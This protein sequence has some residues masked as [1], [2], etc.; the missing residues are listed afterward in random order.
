[1]RKMDSVKNMVRIPGSAPPPRNDRGEIIPVDPPVKQAD[2]TDS[3][4]GFFM[5]AAA[6]L[7]ATGAII[8]VGTSEAEAR[9]KWG[10]PPGWSRGRKRG[11]SKRGGPKRWGW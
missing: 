10:N 3:R 9:P 7:V 5:K 1:M 4:R 2:I 6:L 8:A 11:W